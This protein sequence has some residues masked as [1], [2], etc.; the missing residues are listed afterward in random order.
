MTNYHT[1]YP[2]EGRA[3]AEAHARMFPLEVQAYMEA[4]LWMFTLKGL[5]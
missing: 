5:P 2:L 4:H 3:Y 1:K